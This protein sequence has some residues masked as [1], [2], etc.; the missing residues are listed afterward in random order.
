MMVAS[1]GL[2]S[3]A[4]RCAV[5]LVSHSSGFRYWVG[6]GSQQCCL[7]CYPRWGPWGAGN[8]GTTFRIRLL[9]GMVWCSY[10]SLWEHQAGFFTVCLCYLCYAMYICVCIGCVGSQWPM[11]G[12][13]PIF[14]AFHFNSSSNFFRNF[15]PTN[16][17]RLYELCFLFAHLL[18]HLLLFRAWLVRLRRHVQR[19]GNNNQGRLTFYIGGARGYIRLLLAWW[20]I[21]DGYEVRVLHFI[22]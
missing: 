20:M 22:M 14:S 5:V 16:F 3:S 21:V 17:C 15:L 1:A 2:D 11:A 13:S 6:S 7:M 9:L 18:P 12:Y 4:M 19:R 8:R 10:C